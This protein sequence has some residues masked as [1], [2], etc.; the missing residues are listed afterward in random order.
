MS[1]A[2]MR[3]AGWERTDARP[4]T[5]LRAVWRGP[6]GFRLEHCGHP[7]ANYPWALYD[8]EQRM[9]VMYN[10]RAWSTLEDAVAYVRD[11]AQN[12]PANYGFVRAARPYWR[13]AAS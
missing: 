9:H 5:K 11:G 4:W 7:T 6:R 10:G 12:E 8:E 3:A 1:H 2:A 13:G